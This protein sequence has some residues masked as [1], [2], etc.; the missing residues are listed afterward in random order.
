MEQKSNAAME[1]YNL[2]V[3]KVAE[4]TKKM[5]EVIEL[6]NEEKKGLTE[7]YLAS[8]QVSILLKLFRSCY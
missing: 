7:K 3:S 4:M 6:T 1:K 2:G 8:K 5:N